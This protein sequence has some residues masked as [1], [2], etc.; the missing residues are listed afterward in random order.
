M[1][2]LWTIV[3]LLSA[4]IIIFAMISVWTFFTHREYALTVRKAMESP[5]QGKPNNAASETLNGIIIGYHEQAMMQAKVQFYFGIAAAT[6]GFVWMLVVASNIS[7]AEKLWLIAPGLVVDLVA[8]LFFYQ[9]QQTRERATQLYDRL[10][11]DNQLA[12][13]QKLA[14]C[15]EDELIRSATQAHIAI[16]MIGDGPPVIDFAPLL[17]RTRETKKTE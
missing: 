13:A 3:A 9:A 15:I 1:D 5:Q 14:S 4:I 2:L 8:G 10:R 12:E 11:R 16:Q 6:I 7:E 17:K